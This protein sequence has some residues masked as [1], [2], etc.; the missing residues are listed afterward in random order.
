MSRDRFNRFNFCDDGDIE[1]VPD[2]TLR[3]GR[4]VLFER[5]NNLPPLAGEASVV[6]EARQTRYRVLPDLLRLLELAGNRS[7]RQELVPFNRFASATAD[8]FRA[9]IPRLDPSVADAIKERLLMADTDF[10]YEHR[11]SEK[12]TMI[13]A[14]VFDLQP[15]EGD[16][17]AYPTGQLVTSGDKR[18]ELFPSISRM[19]GVSRAM[20]SLPSRDGMDFILSSEDKLTKEEQVHQTALEAR[21]RIFWEILSFGD[22][23]WNPLAH[24]NV[25]EDLKTKDAQ[26]W[27]AHSK[28]PAKEL[29]RLHYA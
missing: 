20:W 8:R 24:D 4:M 11:D 12:E 9:E 29:I 21:V 18:T 23:R 14:I 5:D 26:F 2:A 28:F 16:S 22:T 25:I 7:S 13:V 27:Y 10:W 19:D 1:S 6:K 3:E 15:M 17:R